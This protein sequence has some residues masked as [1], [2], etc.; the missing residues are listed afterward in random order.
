M[1]VPFQLLILIIVYL[2]PKIS[3]AIQSHSYWCH[4]QSAV[5][6]IQ[7]EQIRRARISV[8]GER[9]HGFLSQSE[10]LN[11]Y[12]HINSNYTVQLFRNAHGYYNLI[13]R[14][15]FK[16]ANDHIR[17]LL[18][19][20]E[21]RLCKGHNNHHGNKTTTN[22]P[23]KCIPKCDFSCPTATSY[24]YRTMNKLSALLF[25]SVEEKNFSFTFVREPLARFISGMT[26]V[27]FSYCTS[28]KI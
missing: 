3:S 11:F 18:Y 23:L 21:H 7:R 17:T 27:F 5:L 4:N 24:L 2:H 14:R 9:H 26:E 1:M 19:N 20:Y 28:N 8:F 22:Q 10:N 13:Y 6:Y 15:L 16:N 25:L 12:K